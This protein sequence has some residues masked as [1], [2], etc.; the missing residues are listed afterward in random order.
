MRPARFPV[1]RAALQVHAHA[2]LEALEAVAA[3]AHARLPVGGTVLGRH[4]RQVI[5]GD[6]IGK[7]DVAR[8][9]LEHHGIVALGANLGDVAEHGLGCR[10]GLVAEV[11]LDR[12]YDIVG[13]QGLAVVE[14]H[15]L[16]QGEG[17][18]PC[19]GAQFPAL[20]QFRN[21]AA[22]HGD[23]AEGVV[24]RRE[25]DKGEGI[26][27]GARIARI[28]GAA[29][30]QAHTQHAAGFGRGLLGPAAHR[31]AKAESAGHRGCRGA[32]LEKIATRQAAVVHRLSNFV[33]VIA[34][35]IAPVEPQRKGFCR[36]R[37]HRCCKYLYLSS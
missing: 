2:G 27:P 24:H 9:Q 16:A 6:H 23:F 35:G 18:D 25:A 19:I 20:G 5:V 22:I 12:S 29:T 21:G 17:P 4:D 30:G 7:V 3:G 1:I 33:V 15:A 10:G 13:V 26:G 34:H 14:G 31:Q 28:G 37:T 8:M 32:V 36:P 11:M